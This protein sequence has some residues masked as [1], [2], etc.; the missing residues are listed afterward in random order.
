MCQL[1][2]I[3]FLDPKLAKLIARPLTELNTVGIVNQSNNDGFGYVC[4][5]NLQDI[6]KSQESAQIWWDENLTTWKRKTRSVNGIYHVRNC[7]QGKDKMGAE[8]AHPFATK[9]LIQIHNGTMNLRFI[10]PEHDK[11]KPLTSDKDID[12]NN[13]L[14]TLEYFVEK[15]PPLKPKHINQAIKN[16]TG[17]FVLMLIDRRNP[18]IVTIAKD[19]IKLL[20]SCKFKNGKSNIG[21]ILNTEKFELEYAANLLVDFAALL[22]IKLTYEIK[23]LR[24]LAIWEYEIGTYELPGDNTVV[25]PA[26]QTKAV[27]KQYPIQKQFDLPIPANATAHSQVANLT[28]NLGLSYLE[29]A[30]LSEILY[31]RNF[32]VL[33]AKEMTELCEFLTQLEAGNYSDKKRQ[34]WNKAL[35]NNSKM[36][37]YTNSKMSFP[38]F[39][40]SKKFLQKVLETCKPENNPGIVH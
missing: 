21:L 10:G 20:H 6:V 35:K 24:K 34:I 38:F 2:L 23:E 19:D 8:H 32:F 30:M 14:K 7:S 22:N 12:S 13:F 39:V 15:D 17:S 1:T 40:N 26:E 25:V 18:G 36:H 31:K 28:Y 5:S 16:W 3:D 33:D 37:L 27:Q 29:L 4:F 9:N 11:L